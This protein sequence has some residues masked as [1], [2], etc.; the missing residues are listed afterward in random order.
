MECLVPA[1]GLA[2]L[3][4]CPCLWPPASWDQRFTHFPR[5]DILEHE[6]FSLKPY[7]IH[8]FLVSSL[9]KQLDHKWFPREEFCSLQKVKIR[10]HL[11]GHSELVTKEP[12]SKR[13]EIGYLVFNNLCAISFLLG[14][15]ILFLENFLFWPTGRLKFVLTLQGPVLILTHYQGLVKQLAHLTD[16][17][18]LQQLQ[19]TWF[20]LINI[21]SLDSRDI[22]IMISSFMKSENPW[23]YLTYTNHRI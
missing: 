20:Q 4:L 18:L 14:W 12:Q 6:H 3:F 7:R 22:M 8:S 23:K 5:Q 15:S 21:H 19:L 11:E 13:R 10:S 1:N 9:S 16:L 17:I 2:Q